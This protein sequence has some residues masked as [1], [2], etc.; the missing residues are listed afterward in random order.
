M[1]KKHFRGRLAMKGSK[2]GVVSG[3][4]YRSRRDFLK[5]GDTRASLSTDGKEKKRKGV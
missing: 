4:G 2:E 3:E 5:M 1:Y